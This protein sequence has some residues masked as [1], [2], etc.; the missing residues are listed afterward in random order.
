MMF[1]NSPPESPSTWSLVKAH[2]PIIIAVGGILVLFVS[3]HTGAIV[4]AGAAGA[5]MLLGLGLLLLRKLRNSTRSG[6]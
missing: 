5:H 1:D 2:I 6:A 3:M 4:V